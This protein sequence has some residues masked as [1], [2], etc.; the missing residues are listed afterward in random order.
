M[1]PEV[2]AR[3]PPV[4]RLR[5]IL[6]LPIL[7]ARFALQSELRVLLRRL[8][9]GLLLLVHDHAAVLGSLLRLLARGP[10]QLQ[11]TAGAPAPQL[12]HEELIDA[13]AEDL[14]LLQAAPPRL[15]TETLVGP[16]PLA[17]DPARGVGL[18]LRA[19][20]LLAV[21][22]EATLPP[23]W[24][25]KAREDPRGRAASVVGLRL[26]WSHL[27]VQVQVVQVVQDF[28]SCFWLRLLRF[29]DE[30]GVRLSSSNPLGFGLP[31]SLLRT[32]FAPCIFS[33]KTPLGSRAPLLVLP[34]FLLHPVVLDSQTVQLPPQAIVLP[35]LLARHDVRAL[36]Q[37]VV[38]LLDLLLRL[39]AFQELVREV[40]RFL[41]QV[42]LLP[43]QGQNLLLLLRHLSLKLHHPLPMQALALAP[44]LLQLVVLLRQGLHSTR[45]GLQP[46]PGFP[47]GPLLSLPLHQLHPQS[48]HLLLKLKHLVRQFIQGRSA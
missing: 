13:F 24:T 16:R 37:I 48:H 27:Y 22:P 7:S 33:R 42:L 17:R 20:G 25:G 9:L 35:L 44:L 36:A 8:G 46:H 14:P 15:R 29:H 34:R 18:L 19:L 2:L 12:G 41:P 5:R 45:L 43:P 6:L 1:K 30:L 39:S 38:S 40:N 32:S 11:G 47:P 26:R 4:V 28:P 3:W 21:A 31:P 23:P 10:L